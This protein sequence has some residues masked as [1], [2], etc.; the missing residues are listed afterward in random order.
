MMIY[1]EKVVEPRIVT[2]SKLCYEVLIR[3][4]KSIERG[5]K[6][7]RKL[8]RA[9]V[10][11]VVYVRELRVDRQVEVDNEG[12]RFDHLDERRRK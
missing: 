10:N 8:E 1:Y 3:E 4:V 11:K 7:V 12:H 2:V 9:V 5:L 6:G